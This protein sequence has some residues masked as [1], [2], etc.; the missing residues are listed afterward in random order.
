MLSAVEGLKVAAPGLSSLV[1]P[2]ALVILTVLFVIQRFGT[3]LDR[4][5]CSAR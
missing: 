2:I 3:G 1:V 4:H 5:G